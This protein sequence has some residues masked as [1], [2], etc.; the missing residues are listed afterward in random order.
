M[1]TPNSGTIGSF[2][3][4]LNE[5]GWSWHYPQSDFI[6]FE[7]GSDQLDKL[8]ISK[9]RVS[10]K[11]DVWELAPGVFEDFER[12]VAFIATTAGGSR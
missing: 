9:E 7:D 2:K 1:S 3:H 8:Y 12:F 6:R 11:C 4:L 10:Y 5:I